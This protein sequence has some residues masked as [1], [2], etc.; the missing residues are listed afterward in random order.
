VAPEASIQAAV[1]H[2]GDGAAFCRRRGAAGCRSSDPNREE[3]FY[4]EAKGSAWRPFAQGIWLEGVPMG[5]ELAEAVRS[6]AR[7]VSY[8]STGP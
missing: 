1:D 3:S 7:P 6:E 4:W 2:A 5:G 8:A